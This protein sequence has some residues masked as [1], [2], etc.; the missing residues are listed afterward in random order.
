MADES[1]GKA[2]HVGGKIQ[3][4]AGEIL[5]DRSMRRKGRLSQVEGEAEQ[6]LERARREAEEAAERK[7]AARSEKRRTR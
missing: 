6:D 1:K 4:K 7:A 5:G 2:K 3:E